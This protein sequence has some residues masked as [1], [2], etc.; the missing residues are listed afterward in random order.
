LAGGGG[1]PASRGRA[2]DC[3]SRPFLSPCLLPLVM[4]SW[5]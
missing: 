4:R 3:D 5:T 1:W 2:G